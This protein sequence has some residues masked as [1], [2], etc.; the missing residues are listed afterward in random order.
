MNPWIDV[1]GWTLVHFLWEGA[2]IAL[3]ALVALWVLRHRSP[4]ARYAVACASLVAMLAA[5]LVTAVVLSRPVEAVRIAGSGEC[6]DTVG[7]PPVRL[8]G[9]CA[10]DAR[11]GD[12]AQVRGWGADVRAPDSTPGCRSS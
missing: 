10:R 4:Q 11:G 3:L 12:S 2:A 7:A 1:A 5:P 6:D 8:A 9:H